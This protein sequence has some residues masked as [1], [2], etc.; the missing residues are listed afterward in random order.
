MRK[1]NINILI[2]IVLGSIIGGFSV[3]AVNTH[4][5][6]DQIIYTKN[7]SEMT[8]T[9]FLN[10]IYDKLDKGDA[11]PKDVLEGKEIIVKGKKVVGTASLSDFVAIVD[12]TL[13][14]SQI[15]QH[16]DLSGK[17]SNQYYNLNLGDFFDNCTGLT[18]DNIAVENY[19]YA[20]TT[21]L[22]T[23]FNYD[24]NYTP[25]TCNLQIHVWTSRTNVTVGK[26]DFGIRVFTLSTE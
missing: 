23:T 11:L 10:D 20:T 24:W 17:S 4:H 26:Q 18:S 21:S 15:N 3:Y 1:I 7:G 9:S 25:S 14:S 2:G 8:T 19:D 13:D 5:Q 22:S 6:S 12:A 16:Y